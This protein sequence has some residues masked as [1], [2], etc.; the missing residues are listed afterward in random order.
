MKI[1]KK[2][3]TAAVK[4]GFATFLNEQK[5]AEKL[6]SDILTLFKEENALNEQN[7]A[8]MSAVLK[9]L[10]GGGVPSSK[11]ETLANQ[12]LGVLTAS[13]GGEESA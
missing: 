12:I 10:A 1:K 11:A 5:R 6:K 9:I 13:A 4:N 3:V 7:D 8:L 2:D